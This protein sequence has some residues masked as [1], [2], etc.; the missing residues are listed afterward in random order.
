MEEGGWK[1]LKIMEQEE[2]AGGFEWNVKGMG[3]R[4]KEKKGGEM[5][6]EL[7]VSGRGGEGKER[8]DRKRGKE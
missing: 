6:V 8:K 1:L 5:I 2:R 4:G 3:I 7:K